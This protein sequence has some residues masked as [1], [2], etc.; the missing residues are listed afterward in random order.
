MITFQPFHD[1]GPYHIGTS[2]LICRT[3]LFLYDRDLR[4]KRV[5]HIL[6]HLK[7]QNLLVLRKCEY[8]KYR[9]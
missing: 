1:G 6:F 4:H 9:N 7:N 3:N 2:P 5:N 8:S